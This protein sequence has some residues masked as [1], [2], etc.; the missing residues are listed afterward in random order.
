MRIWIEIGD[1]WTGTMSIGKLSSL[2]SSPNKMLKYKSM[3]S[4]KRHQII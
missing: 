3:T 2:I 4:M 1:A